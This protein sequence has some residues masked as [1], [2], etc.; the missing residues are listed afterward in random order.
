MI[1]RSHHVAGKISHGIRLLLRFLLFGQF[2][3]EVVQFF[4]QAYPII[5]FASSSS[6]SSGYSTEQICS[7]S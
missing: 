4:G 7:F 2:H 3:D 1:H 6:N 5:L